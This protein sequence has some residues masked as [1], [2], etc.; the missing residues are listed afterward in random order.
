MGGA[1]LISS[2]SGDR[3]ATLIVSL[4]LQRQAIGR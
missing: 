4:L 2:D 3:P 1:R